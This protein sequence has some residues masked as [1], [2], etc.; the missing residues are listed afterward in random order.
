MEPNT[1]ASPPVLEQIPIGRTAPR[2]QGGVNEAEKH[3]EWL[4]DEAIM[5]TFPASDPVAPYQPDL[6]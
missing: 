3:A 2:S 6:L 1:T 4:L 5:E